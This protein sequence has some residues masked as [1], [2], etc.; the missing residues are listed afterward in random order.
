M[1]CE[2]NSMLQLIGLL[3]EIFLALAFVYAL[4]LLRRR[5]LGEIFPKKQPKTDENKDKK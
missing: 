3:F 1:N 2:V 4:Y 5:L